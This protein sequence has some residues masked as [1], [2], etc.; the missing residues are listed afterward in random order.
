MEGYKKDPK[1]EE[2]LSETTENKKIP[3]NVH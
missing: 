1:K 2:L 3:K